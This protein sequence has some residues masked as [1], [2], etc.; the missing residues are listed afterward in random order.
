MIGVANEWSSR[1]RDARVALV[2]C[3]ELP[4]GDADTRLLIEPLAELDIEAV[5]AVWDDA[6]VDW[7]EFDLVIVR[8]CWDYTPRRGEFLGWAESVRHLEN[9]CAVLRWN[10]DKRYLDDLAACGIPVIPTT[11]VGPY[12][13]WRLPPSAGE[14]T[15]YVIKPAFSLCALDSGRYDLGDAEQRRLAEEHV[16][17][18]QAAGRTVMIQPYLTQIDSVGETSLVFFGG[19]FSHALCKGAVLHGPDRGVDNRFSPYGWLDL[20]RREPSLAELSLARRALDAVPGGREQLLY[21]RLDLVPDTDGAL[22]VMEVELT[23]PQL[24]FVWVP[25]AIGRFTSLIADRAHGSTH[26]LEE[27]DDEDVRHG[28]DGHA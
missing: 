6:R 7:N 17:C 23:E 21:A 4:H 13:D 9:R 16:R 5:P 26:R 11:W 20:R 25:E 8:S 15:A 2:T 14:G 12:D 24:Y 18:L 22:V 3:A 1:K 27:H 10:T 28:R 19:R